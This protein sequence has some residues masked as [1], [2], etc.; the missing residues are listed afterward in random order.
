MKSINGGNGCEWELDAEHDATIKPLSDLEITNVIVES[1][2]RSAAVRSDAMRCIFLSFPNVLNHQFLSQSN[3]PQS[4]PRA[5]IRSIGHLQLGLFNIAITSTAGTVSLSH[6]PTSRICDT[7]SGQLDVAS[8]LF[9]DRDDTFESVGTSVESEEGFG[10]RLDITRDDTYY[11]D[12]PHVQNDHPI[13]LRSSLD[14]TAFEN[15]LRS[16][17][18][19]QLSRDRLLGVAGSLESNSVDS[20]FPVDLSC[21]DESGVMHFKSLADYHSFRLSLSLTMISALPCIKLTSADVLHAMLVNDPEGLYQRFR[22]TCQKWTQWRSIGAGFW[23]SVSQPTS[24]SI[25]ASI[26]AT[27]VKS[28]VINNCLAGHEDCLLWAAAAGLS[29]S[30]T[31]AWQRSIWK[32][33]KQKLLLSGDWKTDPEFAKNAFRTAMAHRE[34]GQWKFAAAILIWLG[35]PKAAVMDCIVKCGYGGD[36]QLGL[37]VVSALGL[38]DVKA[39]LLAQLVSGVSASN[40]PW[41][42]TCLKRIGGSVDPSPDVESLHDDTR[43]YKDILLCPHSPGFSEVEM[44]HNFRLT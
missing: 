3:D 6:L 19:K 15:T 1:V 5:V 36:A 33:P 37:L 8:A 11:D 17:L 31:L 42:M 29:P 18:L 21:I 22:V 39:L 44:L 7:T 41:M 34:K 13:P 40:D 16:V 2:L 35:D 23:A 28:C 4:A 24:K 43:L 32:S 12:G 26:A 20:L 27:T 25:V 9:A 10:C 38:D 30:A 14:H